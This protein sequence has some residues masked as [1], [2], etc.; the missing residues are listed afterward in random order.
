MEGL[1]FFFDFFIFHQRVDAVESAPQVRRILRSPMLKVDR[2]QPLACPFLDVTSPAA[3]HLPFGFP[4]A[5]A[6][7]AVIGKGRGKKS[8]RGTE[9]QREE[10][11]EV[12]GARG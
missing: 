11:D 2:T 5:P 12:S 6:E 10:Q 1:S 4:M 3:A 7:G 9:Q 8:C